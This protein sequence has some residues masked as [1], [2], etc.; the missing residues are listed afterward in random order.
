MVLLWCRA[1]CRLPCLVHRHPPAKLAGVASETLFANALLHVPH[2][3]LDM[4]GSCPSLIS[5]IRALTIQMADSFGKVR[6]RTAARLACGFGG[7]TMGAT[8]AGFYQFSLEIM[9]MLLSCSIPILQEAS[10]LEE[11]WL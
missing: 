10:V 2:L 1:I 9:P 11:T 8:L 7:F 3:E 6:C 4:F 5:E